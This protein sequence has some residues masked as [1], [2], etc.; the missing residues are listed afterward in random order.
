MLS[1]VFAGGD[2]VSGNNLAGGNI[3][4]IKMI[5]RF[6]FYLVLVIGFFVLC[7]NLYR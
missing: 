4:D 1:N 5:E 6:V 2:S 3:G 7:Y